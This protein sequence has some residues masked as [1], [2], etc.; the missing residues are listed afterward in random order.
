V[1]KNNQP[2]RPAGRVS[3]CIATYNG[4]RFIREQLDSILRQL[5]EDDEIVICDD[6]ST[7]ETLPAVESYSD[8]RIRMHR[9]PV[10]LGHAQ[11]FMK[12]I[13]LARGEYIALSDQ[14]DIWV[15]GRLA[16]MLHLLSGL[17]PGSLVI[18]EFITVDEANRECPSHLNGLSLGEPSPSGFVQLTKILAGRVKYFGCTFVFGRELASCF[19]PMPCR[20]EAHDVWIA[21]NACLFSRLAHCREN[22]LRHRLHGQNLTPTRRRSLG[23]IARSRMYYLF[24]L[25]VSYCRHRL[26]AGIKS[27]I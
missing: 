24:H 4:G 9:N 21:I 23:M 16:R 8:S 2:H 26:L 25:L 11:N 19:A 22:T 14:D 6:G 27:V 7:D 1:I 13:A 17:P 10:R 20:I 15:E 18:G 12:A 3:V 5:A